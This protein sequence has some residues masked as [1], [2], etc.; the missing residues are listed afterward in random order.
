MPNVAEALR[1]F[2]P[3][4]WGEV[5]RF[6]TLWPTTYQFQGHQKRVLAGV[7]NHFHKA[8]TL[9]T[10]AESLVPSLKIDEAELDKHGFTP[11]QNARNLAAVLEAVITELYSVIDC[12]AKVLHIVYGPSSMRYRDSTRRLFAEVDAITGSFPERLKAA[13]RAATWYDDLRHIRDELTHRDVGSCSKD[14]ET[15]VIRYFHSSLWDGERQRPIDDIFGWTKS[16]VDAVNAFIGVT[17]NE[18]NASIT[19][20]TVTQMCGMVQ[21]RMLMRV[22]DVSEPID[23][24]NGVCLSAQWFTQP[25]NPYCPFAESCGAFQRRAI[26]DQ[27]H[28]VGES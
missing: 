11:A 13:V 21:G 2:A 27:A 5:D 28:E 17:F 15:G 14:R 19:S 18:L 6:L 8:L 4:K 22:L 23:F 26:A 25:G 1:I 20:G 16:N 12:T 10:M 9:F 3:E 7:K 24:N